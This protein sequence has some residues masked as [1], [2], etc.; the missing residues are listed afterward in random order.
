[1]LGVKSKN[2]HNTNKSRTQLKLQNQFVFEVVIE[3]K[4]INDGQ[5]EIQPSKEGNTYVE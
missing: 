2:K 5:H 3:P 4:K 1:V